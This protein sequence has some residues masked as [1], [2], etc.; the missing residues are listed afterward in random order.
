MGGDE[1]EEE[2]EN[3]HAERPV[4]L[5]P[6]LLGDSHADPGAIHSFL[7]TCL[8]TSA[9]V[10]ELPCLIELDP[11]SEPGETAPSLAACLQGDEVKDTASKPRRMTGSSSHSDDWTLL[12]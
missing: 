1:K 2:E 7:D 5:T 8:G 10:P 3:S 12:G 11:A 4:L 6:D 9:E